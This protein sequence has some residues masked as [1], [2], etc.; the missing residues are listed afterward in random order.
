MNLGNK[1][2]I[3]VMQK[4]CLNGSCP[5]LEK[6]KT[7]EEK[8]SICSKCIDKVY[9]YDM[10]KI[11]EEL[12]KQQETNPTLKRYTKGKGLELS[13]KDIERVLLLI[14]DGK[15]TNQIKEECGYS[16]RTI[17][18]IRNLTFKNEDNNAKIKQIK[19]QLKGK[20]KL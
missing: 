11:I 14:N 7:Y 5:K 16:W 19:Q 10:M 8:V 4:Y 12:L 15:S 6:G 2:N 3:V 17:D 13:E 18:N 9:K 20:G 1:N